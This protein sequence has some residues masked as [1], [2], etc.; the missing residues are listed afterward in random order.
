MLK[1]S[2]ECVGGAATP[3]RR[4]QDGEK[5]LPWG[6]PAVL[7]G[8]PAVIITLHQQVPSPDSGREV[9]MTQEL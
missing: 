1:R 2:L 6:D 5:F 7:V 3:A 9:D 4:F 8:G